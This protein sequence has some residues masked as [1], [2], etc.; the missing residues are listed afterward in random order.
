MVEVLAILSAA[1]AGGLRLAL[2]LLLIGLLQGEQL[3]S[4]VPLLRHLS[5]YWV[6]GVLTAWSFVE[7]FLAG[8]LWG[9]RLIVLVQLCFSPLV[10]ALLGITVATATETPQWLIGTLSGLFA[11]VLQLVQVGWFY[12]LGKLPRWVVVGQDVLCVLLI[13]FALKAPKQGGLIA[14]LLL[15]LAVRS[16][17]DWQQRHRRSRYRQRSS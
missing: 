10:G 14:L 12:R 16:A 2:P 17:K 9:Y 13:L 5:P 3:W 11:F 15:W 1:A 4:Q 7:I 6:V 8:N